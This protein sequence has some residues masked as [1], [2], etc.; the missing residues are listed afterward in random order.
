MPQGQ[1]FTYAVRAQGRLHIAGGVRRTSSC[2]RTPTARWCGVKDVGPH[3]ARRAELQHHGRLNGKPGRARR[4]L[5]AAR[6]QR[7]SQA[8]RSARKT[9]GGAEGA[10]PG[11]P[12]LRGLPRHDAGRHRGHGRD[13]RTRS[14]EALVLV[15]LVVFIFLQGWRATLIPL[16]AVPVSLV[17]TFALFPLFGLLDQHALA[18]RPGAGHRPGGGRRDR[19]GRGRRAPHRARAVAARRRRFKAMEEVTGPVDRRSR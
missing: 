13:R 3:R 18:L 14:F 16:L 17:G 6:L 10:L 11:R 8:A 19:G 7:A 15:I 12:R 2:A 9:D 4:A 5:P 1:E